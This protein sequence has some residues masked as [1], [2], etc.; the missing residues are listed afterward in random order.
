MDWMA[1]VVGRTGEGGMWDACDAHPT[2]ILLCLKSSFQ[3]CS[4]CHCKHPL[5]KLKFLLL[6]HRTDIAEYI[7]Q[8]IYIMATHLQGM[9][10]VFRSPGWRAEAF[11]PV[12]LLDEDQLRSSFGITQGL[13]IFMCFQ[14]FFTV[15]SQSCR[16]LGGV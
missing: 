7:S 9:R 5:Y 13:C 1:T 8:N 12:K 6:D 10:G 4:F 15:G 16:C 3:G 14:E 2:D 11:V